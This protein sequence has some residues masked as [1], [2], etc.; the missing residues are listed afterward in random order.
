MK[1]YIIFMVLIFSIAPLFLSCTK[2][3]IEKAIRGKLKSANE[4]I[5][6][7]N[8]CQSCHL[9]ADFVPEL[10]ILK[11]Q[12]KYNASPVLSKST[13]CLQCHNLKLE[14]LFSREKR[15]TNTSH[16][17]LLSI[18]PSEKEFREKIKL[19]KKIKRKKKKKMERKWY[20]FYLY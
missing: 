14:N 7:S 18:I 12:K 19:P 9:H 10:H 8:H 16:G 6:V 20:F 3:P 15:F 5:A 4:N 17:R 2:S 13:R 1:K 11:M